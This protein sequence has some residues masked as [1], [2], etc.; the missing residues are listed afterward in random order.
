MKV[1]EIV[2]LI[3]ILLGLFLFGMLINLDYFH[4]SILLIIGGLI[5]FILYTKN[6]YAIFGLT[7]LTFALLLYL[8]TPSPFETPEN[9]TN[10]TAPFGGYKLP[11]YY[12]PTIILFLIV[13]LG[14]VIAYKG[15]NKS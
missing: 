3:G 2:G 14:F 4:L 6:T 10:I 11:S 13:I 12:I 7:I 5:F 8:F 9:Q 15:I 1:D